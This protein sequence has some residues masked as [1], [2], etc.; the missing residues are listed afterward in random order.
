MSKQW[1]NDAKAPSSTLLPPPSL[2][3]QVVDSQQCQGTIVCTANAAVVEI[4]S[5]LG[6]EPTMDWH[7]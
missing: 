7:Q 2:Q 6:G 1:T 5:E 4:G 3:K